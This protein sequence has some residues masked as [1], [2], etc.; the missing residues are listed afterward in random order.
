MEKVSSNNKDRELY[1]VNQIACLSIR[2]L[3]YINSH[4]QPVCNR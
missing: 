2:F 3:R 4:I 1:K